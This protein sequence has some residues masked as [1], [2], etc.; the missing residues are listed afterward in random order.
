[1][2]IR[3]LIVSM[4]LVCAT[5]CSGG[6]KSTD[7][8]AG[9]SDASGN[10]A[11]RDARTDHDGNAA[12]PSAP[13]PQEDSSPMKVELQL[14]GTGSN[15]N[16][17]DPTCVLDGVGGSF[18]GSIVGTGTIDDSGAYTSVLAQQDGTFTTPSGACVLDEVD[19]ATLTDVTVHAELQNTEPNCST[20]C[21][22]SARADA[23]EQCGS[24]ASDA[25][26]R[27]DAEASAEASCKTECTG[28][29]TRRIVADAHL[30]ASEVATMNAG[31]LG[32]TGVG[33]VTA[34]LTFDH[35]DEASP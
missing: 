14:S 8:T 27:A 18:T 3:S 17:V 13:A 20:Y 26:C 28:S 21:A 32:L 35:T 7:N 5:A 34:D 24:D 23:E 33:E 10:A 25:S 12:E 11:Y 6:T 30:S 1:M 19:I 4:A 15:L 16:S 31:A 22:S 29:T 2:N 9:D